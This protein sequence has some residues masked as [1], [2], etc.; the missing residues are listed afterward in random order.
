MIFGLLNGIKTRN[1]A[2]LIVQKLLRQ[3]VIV[4]VNLTQRKQVNRFAQQ[5][6]HQQP[7][8]PHLLVAQLQQLQLPQL[9]LN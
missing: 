2:Q 6:Q 4:I 8:P 1:Q 9:L 7:Q 5:K 3:M